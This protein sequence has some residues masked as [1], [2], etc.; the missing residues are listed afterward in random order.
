MFNNSYF[1]F[2]ILLAGWGGEF[3][4]SDPYIFMIAISA[5]IIISYF[6]NVISRKTN[7][8]SVLLLIITG[9]LIKFGFDT[10]AEA[11]YMDTFDMNLLPMLK[12]LGKIGL[13]MIVMEAA[14]ELELH[15]NKI[16]LIIKAMAL[17]IIGLVGCA[18]LIGYLFQQLLGMEFIQALIY[19]TPLSV[20]S[21]AIIIPSVGNLS[22]MNKEF[23]IYEST[24][25]DILGIVM[26][27]F[28]IQLSGP[29]SAGLSATITNYSAKLGITFIIAIAVSYVLVLVF[30]NMKT[31]IKNFLLIAILLLLYSIG[32]LAGLM[33]L[34]II[35]F[36]GLVLANHHIFFFGPLKKFLKPKAAHKFEEELFIVAAETAFVTRTFFFVV[37]GMTIVLGSLMNKYVVLIS[38]V[39]IGIIYIVRLV[40][41]TA[42]NWKGS[43]PTSYIAS[44]GLITVLLFYQIP[45]TSLFEGFNQGILLWIIIV[46]N[47]VMT[48]G[49]IFSGK[50]VNEK[51]MGDTTEDL[52]KMRREITGRSVENT[53]DH[54]KL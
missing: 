45:E 26:F 30:Q 53:N 49:L 15:R 39:I 10:A 28:L 34:I 14:L 17:A 32:E 46:T 25:S 22:K 43:F 6:F 1:H 52:I 54:A 48:L 40:S 44:R 12:L 7:I 3:D 13:V 41:N 35:L 2:M 38:A 9:V 36:F 23:M 47:V 4:L 18:F 20:L 24:F 11:G 16:A 21:S 37:F 33:P 42:L 27:Y 31:Q 5:V 29:E 19:A 50:R 51:T 8:P